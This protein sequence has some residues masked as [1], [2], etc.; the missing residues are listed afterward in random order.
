MST[1]PA[2]DNDGG[3]GHNIPTPWLTYEQAAQYLSLTQ[4]TLR[5][6]VSARQIPVYGSPRFRRFRAD[7]LDLWVRDRANA[8]RKWTEEKRK[9]W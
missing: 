4:A 6:L 2:N 3:S 1:K 7:M 8:M 9:T 5:G